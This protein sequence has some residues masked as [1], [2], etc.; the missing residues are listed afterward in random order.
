MSPKSSFARAAVLSPLLWS[1][2]AAQAQT[3]EPVKPEA[4]LPQIK[5]RSAVADGTTENS[6]SYT[7]NAI[8]IGGSAQTLRETPQSVSVVTRE[9]IDDLNA[10][11]LGDAMKYTTGMKTT[12]YGTGTD[13]IESRGYM[14]DAWQLDGMPVTGGNG[15]WSSSFFD[16]VLFDRIEVWRGPAG[17]LQGMGDPGGTVSLV[18]KR[19][20][21]VF[22]LQGSVSAGSWDRYRLEADVT[23]PLNADGS[24]R[25]RA[26]AAYDDRHYFTDYAWSRRPVF[27]GTL[28]YDVQPGTTLSVGAARQEGTHRPFYGLSNYEDRLGGVPRSAFLGASWQRKHEELTLLFA[29]AEH[30]VANAGR[31]KLRVQSLDRESRTEHQAWGDSFIDPATGNV[32]MTPMAMATDE[33]DRSVLAQWVQP[34]SFRGRSH[35]M[36]LG[37][38]YTVHKGG[39][40]YN[41]SNYGDGAVDQNIFDPDIDLPRPYL[42]LDPMPRTKVEDTGVFGQLRF[43][44]L[45][46]VAV[47]AGGRLGWWKQTDPDNPASDQKVDA[48]FT[49]YLGVIGDVARDW[50]V[51]ASYS[52]IFAPQLYATTADGSALPPRKG[53]QLEFGVKGE[54]FDKTLNTHLAVFRIEDVNRAITDPDDPTGMG[55]IA[56]GKVRSQ[57]LEAEVSGRLTPNW[58]VSAGYAYTDTEYVDAPAEQK[59]RSFATEFPK[60][61]FNLWTKYRLPESIA[62]AWVGGGVR[63]AGKTYVDDGTHRWDQG[64]FTVAS[65]Q[66]GY[67]FTPQLEATLTVNNLFDKYYYERYGWTRQVYFGEPRNAIATLRYRY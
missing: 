49:P 66:A 21:N 65:L 61:T 64:G 37:T 39:S 41:G 24:L 14:L 28:E 1:S 19:A 44:P 32:L 38:T 27:Y 55:S 3:A 34:L 31:L 6:G 7:T 59:G 26:V 45:D 15:S 47:L 36:M 30:A 10:T 56:A 46:G 22:E 42:P 48:K 13:G 29:E 20:G 63:Y 12:S 50:S 67:R 5:V 53:R 57:G 2:L 43:R 33:T 16:L 8:T 62:P 9:K 52:Q 58:D 51:Y 17:L 11:S 23:G 40:T 4:A 54:H 25:G 60:N 18:R 35:E